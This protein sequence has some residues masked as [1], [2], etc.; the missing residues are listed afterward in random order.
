[1]ETN[2]W[3]VGMDEEELFE[4]AMHDRQY[5]DYKTG[6]AKK[7]FEEELIKVRSEKT[8]ASAPVV[9]TKGQQEEKILA[10]INEKHPNAKPILA[11][12]TGRLLW[13][14]DFENKSIPPAPGTTYKENDLVA[15]IQAYYGVDD[16]LS[17]YNGK[18]IDT[19]V[20]QGAMV[21]KGEI[22]GWLE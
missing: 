6:V 4:L 15:H 8:S 22:L 14:I 7:R 5:R 11:S 16:I 10:Y 17:A 12:S 1:M 19:A 21:K 20:K 2:G 9:L 18:L 3:D 13:E